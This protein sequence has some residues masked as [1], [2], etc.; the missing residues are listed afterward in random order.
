[1]LSAMVVLS[2]SGTVLAEGLV[3]GGFEAV[4]TLRDTPVNTDTNGVTTQAGSLYNQT[5]TPGAVT[6]LDQGWY[7]G[8]T[9][10]ITQQGTTDKYAQFSMYSG[11]DKPDRWAIGQMFTDSSLSGEK[12]IS[13]DVVLDDYVDANT[14]TLKIKIFTVPDPTVNNAK[15]KLVDTDIS[16]FALLGMQEVDIS[17]GNGS[18]ET[19]AIDFTA[20]SSLY[21]ITIEA[22]SKD[23][24]DALV[25][26][27]GSMG[28]DNIQIVP[29]P[30]TIGMLGLGGL[31]TLLAR[32]FQR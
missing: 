20:G 2:L 1:M 30:A 21:A 27:S 24:T 32:R 23:G 7:S 16:S 22:Y 26:A 28:L 10:E 29:E 8:N 5:T 6:T 31:I 17:A 9:T 15:V 19:A 25:A 12:T 13:F 14:Q 18:Y 11:W 4:G 3:D